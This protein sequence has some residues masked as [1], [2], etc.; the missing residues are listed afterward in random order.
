MDTPLLILI[1]F[2]AI[3]GLLLL[4]ALIMWVKM[5][6]F[7][8]KAIKA[9]GQVTGVVQRE[10]R[11][12]DGHSTIL[13][14]PAVR[15]QTATGQSI[16][17][18]SNVATSTVPQVGAPVEVLYAPDNPQDAKVNHGCL[19]LGPMLFAFIGAIMAGV[20]VAVYLFA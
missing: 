3:G 7:L 14:A 19:W 9:T 4:V 15:F 5:I 10:S 18:V 17:F 13:H 20:G 8:G 16:D 1:I 6:K 11:D 12:D 2:G